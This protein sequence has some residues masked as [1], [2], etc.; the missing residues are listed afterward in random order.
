MPVPGDRGEIPGAEPAPRVPLAGQCQ[1][2]VRPGMQRPVDPPRQVHPE[3]RQCRIRYRVDEGADK[4]PAHME[5]LATERYD[6]DLPRLAGEPVGEQAGTVDHEVGGYLLAVG[7]ADPAV[8]RGHPGAQ[9]D[10]A[11]VLA[12]Q[13]G[14]HLAD[15]AEVGDPGRLDVQRGQA[16]HLRLAFARGGGRQ[17]PRRYPVG[18]RPFGQYPQPRQLRLR[19]GDDELAAHLDGYPVLLAELDHR[20]RPGDAQPGPVA[21]RAVVDA[22]VDHAR[23]VPGLVRAD[24]VL[25][26]QDGDRRAWTVEQQPVGD[27]QPDDATPHDD[28]PVH[29]SKATRHRIPGRRIPTESAAAPSAS[30]PAM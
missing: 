21:T 2:R 11:A 1:H 28:V 6:P 14:E 5:V 3:E 8:E 15:R 12:Y 29:S 19:R 23:V 18:L 17:H 13:A 16:R 26:L 20:A 4:R 7:G 9:P 30:R 27:R 25:L 10:L 22:R 24:P